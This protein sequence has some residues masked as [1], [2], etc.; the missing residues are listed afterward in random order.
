MSD[1][2]TDLAALRIDQT[3]RAGGG[4]RKGLWITLVLIVLA[5]AGA[6]LYWTMGAQAAPVKTAMVTSVTGGA[7]APGAVLNASGYVTARRRA[8]VSSKVTGKVLEV[9]VKDTR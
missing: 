6:G 3:A 4:S 8:T 7:V 1:L 2:K 5:V 9:S